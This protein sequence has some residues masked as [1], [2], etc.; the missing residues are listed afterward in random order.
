MGWKGV[1]RSMAAASRAAERERERRQRQYQKRM[2]AVAKQQALDDAQ[3]AAEEYE[4]Y[5]AAL[6]TLHTE[7]LD[8]IDWAAKARAKHP[9]PP[10]RSDIHE[11]KAEAAHD[12]YRPSIFDKVFGRKDRR[13]AA[14]REDRKS[15][16]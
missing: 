15:V 5:V 4:D 2:A 9:P 16:V 11:R 7:G 12:A 6:V 1:V 10:M 8:A 13:L 3:E 14:L